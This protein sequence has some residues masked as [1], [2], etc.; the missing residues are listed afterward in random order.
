MYSELLS[1]LALRFIEKFTSFQKSQDLEPMLKKKN[2]AA[3]KLNL[4]IHSILVFRDSN[5]NK[6]APCKHFH[7]GRVTTKYI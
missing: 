1:R 5:S 2:Q 6:V 3:Q 4:K 7:Q